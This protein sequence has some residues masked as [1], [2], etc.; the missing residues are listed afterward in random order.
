MERD[1]IKVYNSSDLASKALLL[2]KLTRN[3]SHHG[4]PHK[5]GPKD[6]STMTCQQAYRDRRYDLLNIPFIER[7]FMYLRIVPGSLYLDQTEE[8]EEYPL[9]R[10]LGDVGGCVGLW[11]GASLITLFEFLD[12]VLDFV[13]L[14]SFRKPRG[15][16]NGSLSQRDDD[17]DITNKSTL[18]LEAQAMNLIE[19]HDSN[20]S[21]TLQLEP[22]QK[23]SVA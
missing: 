10:L 19:N 13:G 21:I 4:K 23:N 8:S 3:D 22:P 6:T 17:N 12:L 11:V 18:L 2:Y 1:E 5:R 7:N 20:S 9:S 14:E 16:T 15:M